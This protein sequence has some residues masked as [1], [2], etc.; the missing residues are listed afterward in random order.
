M[1]RVVAT[2]AMMRFVNANPDD[3]MAIKNG[4]QPADLAHARNLLGQLL[5]SITRRASHAYFNPK[6]K[7]Q[8]ILMI[9][10][11]IWSTME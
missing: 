8:N 7:V 2:E 3:V 1:L 11:P 9:A 6:S 4:E 5:S 10:H